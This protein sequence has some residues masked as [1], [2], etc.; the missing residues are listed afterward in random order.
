[1]INFALNHASHLKYF[2][3][4]VIEGN[5]RNIQSFFFIKDNP[6]KYCCPVKNMKY[7]DILCKQYKIKKKNISELKHSKNI[8]F[9]VEGHCLEYCSKES[10]KIVLTSQSDF[11]DKNKY[12]KYITKVNNVIFPSKKLAEYYNCI[13]DKNL[14]LGSPKYDLT[15]NNIEIK[16][17]Y[18][19]KADKNILI[20]YPIN[21]CLNQCK[22][23]LIDIYSFCKENGYNILVKTRGKSKC[24]DNNLKGNI[25]FEDG[26]WFPHTTLE[27]LKISDLVVN[28]SSTT[29]KEAIMMRTPM[30]NY[31]IDREAIR[32]FEFMYNYDFII[33]R[34]LEKSNNIN[35]D[36]EILLNSNFTEE[37]N[38]A[39]DE[40]LFVSGKSSEKILNTCV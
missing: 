22:H 15:Y 38:R 9:M 1:M 7:I 21:R 30:L 19:I 2:I 16:E 23:L 12:K 13:S 40:C 20:M 5:K 17:K 8:V 34:G 27:L 11:R 3:P 33:E 37:Y 4:L 31:K 39:I 25:Y 14:Y 10:K 28:F 24:S 26:D 6:A 29:V 36:F 32:G 18:N 35:N